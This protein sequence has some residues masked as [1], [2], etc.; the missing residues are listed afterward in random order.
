MRNSTPDVLFVATA[1]L[2]EIAL[3]VHF[4]VRRWRLDVAV[5]Y[6]PIV[7]AL[8]V[9][10]ATVSGILLFGG[11][12]WWLWLGG[13]LFLLWAAFGFVVEY[14]GKVQ[15]RDPIRWSVFV[16]YVLLCLATSMFYWWPL[17]L[18]WKP[19][20][21]VFAAFFVASTVLNVI[22]HRAPRAYRRPLDSRDL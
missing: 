14:V 11:K 10:A 5:R 15:W 18:I 17:A 13:V 20:W 9:P 12:A 7:Y 19:L 2:F 8:S 6:G 4:A 21:Y 22:S 1:F 3:V 16:P